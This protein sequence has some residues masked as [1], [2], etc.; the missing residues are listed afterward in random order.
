M[1]STNGGSVSSEVMAQF[2]KTLATPTQLE[3]KITQSQITSGEIMKA[4]ETTT[5]KQQITSGI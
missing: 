2:Q 5:A 1:I 3:N 4:E